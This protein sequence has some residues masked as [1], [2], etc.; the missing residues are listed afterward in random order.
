VRQRIKEIALSELGET[1]PRFGG[2]VETWC[3]AFVA[4]VIGQAGLRSPANGPTM[5]GELVSWLG[6]TTMPQVGDIAVHKRVDHYSIIVEIRGRRVRVVEGGAFDHVV[7]DRF[8]S[9]HELKFYSI[10]RLLEEY[11]YTGASAG[12]LL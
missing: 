8:K 5:G 11:E 6:P 1:W 7:R 9:W 10:D 12:P 4:W 3:G 2:P